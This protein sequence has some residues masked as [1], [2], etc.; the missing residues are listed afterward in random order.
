MSAEGLP[1]YR[2]HVLPEHPL[3]TALFGDDRG[4]G[5]PEADLR[6]AVEVLTSTFE[7]RPIRGRM[8][9]DRILEEWEARTPDKPLLINCF[10]L[11][12]LLV[13]R[14]RACGVSP[15]RAFVVLCG[16]RSGNGAG[17]HAC[18]LL[19]HGPRAF[20]LDTVDL[21]AFCTTEGAALVGARRYHLVFNDQHVYFSEAD[22]RRALS[23]EARRSGLRKYLYGSDDPEVRAM[24]EDPSFDDW[25]A[26]CF[27]TGTFDAEALELR[28]RA[29]AAGL[30]RRRDG[31]WEAG[32]RLVMVSEQR[33]REFQRMTEPLLDVYLGIAGAALPRIRRAYEETSTAASYGWE[34]V[35]HS[36]GA[37]MFLDLSVGAHLAMERSVRAHLGPSVVW[38]F[39]NVSA[40]DG[41]GV[42]WHPFG[43]TNHRALA[44]LWHVR[45]PRSPL[46]LE[47]EVGRD[48]LAAAA[49]QEP[50]P[51][52]SKLVLTF[53]K[54]VRGGEP[55]VPVFHPE[56]S[57]RVLAP[58]LEAAER[59]VEEVVSPTFALLEDHPWWRDHEG[60]RTAA[61]R[62]ILEYITTRSV[63]AGLLP[64]FPDGED[65]P[66]SWGRWIWLE[67]PGAPSRLVP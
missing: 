30:L 38:V 32:P 3:L 19:H 33:E 63:E 1:G 67:P 18:A 5:E 49:E 45:V 64:P 27:A 25:A 40:S 14:L 59:I 61:V 50:L 53:L 36:L 57:D 42:Q 12:A 4:S 48:L 26:G 13:S 65:A 24:L 21:G 60:Q 11:A 2:R 39:E 56:D 10:D 28:E 22:K 62:L 52:R 44:Q 43:G 6:R 37:G 31:A 41:F 66:P 46:G 17:F 16:S 34:E 15:D 35:C 29:E 7:Y 55:A 8:G 9:F 58:M 20:W 47:R 54:L 51:Q 23:G